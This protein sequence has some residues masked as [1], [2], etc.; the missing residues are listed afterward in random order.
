MTTISTPDT[1]FSIQLPGRVQTYL[2]AL[3]QT[4]ARDGA[5]LVSVVLFGSAAK[6]GFSGEVS[7]V[8]LIIVVSDDPPRTQR[9]QLAEDVARLEALHG[10]RPATTHSPRRLRTFIERVM[11]HGFSY[12]VCTR[13]DLISGDVARVLGV[14]PLEAPFVDRIVFAT[15]VASAVTVWGEDLLPQVAVPS[16]RRLDVFKALLTFSNQVLL[17]AV[18][19]PVL[20]DATRYAMGALKH[21]L[22]SCFFCYHRRTAAVEVEVDFFQ[23]RMGPSQTL[24]DL[25]ALRRESRRSFAFVVRCLPTIVRLHVRTS[26]D[27]RFAVGS[28]V[29]V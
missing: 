19:F 13:G 10:L 5:P 3:I 4:C 7:D 25:L 1:A 29:V 23:S 21:S 11:S 9:R 6:G 16:V 24:V 27:N 28:S 22:H 17:S 20:P 18:A 8:D 26:W 15:I 2:E 12:F 14:R